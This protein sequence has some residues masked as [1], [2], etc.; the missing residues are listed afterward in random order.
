MIKTLELEDHKCIVI[1]ENK[2]NTTITFE[3][4]VIFDDIFQEGIDVFKKMLLKAIEGELCFDD[5]FIEKGIG[6]WWNEY[7]DSYDD[8]VEPTE[9]IA[10]KYWLWSCRNVQ[11]WLYSVDDVIYIEISLSYPWH[12][13]EPKEGE[14]AI[15]FEEFQNRH[16]IVDI[17]KIKFKDV[18]YIIKELCDFEYH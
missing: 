4:Q 10:E 8:A 11:S 6:Y 14:M 18:E 2:Y 12:F 16:N 5:R 1:N 15:K 17:L 13:I 7:T 3:E 9:D